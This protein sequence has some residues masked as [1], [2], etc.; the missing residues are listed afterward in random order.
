MND[1]KYCLVCDVCGFKNINI[2]IRGKELIRRVTD[3]TEFARDVAHDFGIDDVK[4]CS[5]TLFAVTDNNEKGLSNLLGFSKRLLEVGIARSF[6]LRGG[7]SFGR[8][9]STDHSLFGPAAIGAYE[10]SNKQDWFGICCDFSEN[11]PSFKHLKKIWDWDI[12]FMYSIPFKDGEIMSL[13]VVSWNVPNLNDLLN[14]TTDKGLMNSKTAIKW[15]EWG[16]KFQNTVIFSIYTKI[17]KTTDKDP[18]IFYGINPMEAIDLYLDV[19]SIENKS[20]LN[21]LLDK[22]IPLDLSQDEMRLRKLNNQL[23]INSGNT[24]LLIN[25]GENLINLFRYR[26]AITTLNKVIKLNPTVPEAW[27]KKGEAQLRL[28]EFD[29]S[30]KSINKALELNPQLAEAWNNMGVAKFYKGNYTESIECFKKAVEFDQKNETSLENLGY[31]LKAAGREEESEK[32]YAKL[33]D[34]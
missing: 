33:W 10:L 9:Y 12:V 21:K 20:K 15:N 14:Y 30:I 4:I 32:V 6:P 28:G 8:V 29:S 19:S 13:P 7:I 18:K 23:K 3:W 26:E 24:T 1:L 25:K 5:D 34:L 11:S 2:N 17:M 22:R 16:H 27:S 31:S